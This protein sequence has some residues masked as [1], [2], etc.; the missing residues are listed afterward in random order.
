MKTRKISLDEIKKYVYIKDGKLYY[1]KN[2]KCIKRRKTKNPPILFET[3]GQLI[4]AKNDTHKVVRKI[5][6]IKSYIIYLYK[7]IFT[8]SFSR[9]LSSKS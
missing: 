6:S 8:F 1:T 9:M 5:Y 3:G 7:S 2:N 4:R